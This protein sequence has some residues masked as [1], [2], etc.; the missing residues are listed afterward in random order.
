MSSIVQVRS[1]YVSRDRNPWFSLDYL[2]GVAPIV[3]LII[4]L[5]VLM[6]RMA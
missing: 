5:V 4:L 6:L 1:E 3:L 2:L